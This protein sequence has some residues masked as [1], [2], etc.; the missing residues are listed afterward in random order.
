M[1]DHLP[2]FESEDIRVTISHWI[3]RVPGPRNISKTQQYKIEPLEIRTLLSGTSNEINF[4]QFE[5]DAP[6]SRR[7]WTGLQFP[8]DLLHPEQSGRALL[9]AIDPDGEYELVEVKHGLASSHSRFRQIVNG[10]PVFGT[11]VSAHQGSDGLIHTLHMQTYEQPAENTSPQI[12]EEQSIAISARANGVSQI[13]LEPTGQLVWFAT[14]N[15]ELQLAWETSVSSR[16][17]VV[18][19]FRTVI[20]AQTG[21]VLSKENRIVFATGSGDSFVPNP[22]QTQGNGT[23]LDDNNDANS[24]ALEAQLVSVTLERLDDG[25]GLLIGEWADLATFNS[26]TKPDND[27][28]EANRIYEYTRDD[29]RFE[30]VV[31]YHAIDSIQ[32]YFHSLGFDDDTGTANGIR[33]FPTL[34]NAHW[35]DDDQSF[36]STANDALHF[37]DGGVD[38]GEDQDI[39]A[40][41]YGHAVQHNQNANWSGGEMGAM[42]EGFG[43]YLAASFYADVGDANYQA[44]NAACVGEWDATEFSSTSPPCLRRVDGDKIYPDDLT[45]AIHAD[46]EIWSA[47]LWDIRAELGGPVTDQLVL[48]HHFALPAN[49]LMPDAANAVLQADVDLNNGDNQAE[50]LAAFVA[51]GILE[52]GPAGTISFESS[53][54]RIGDVATITVTDTDLIGQPSV[55]I[56]VVATSGDSETV[57]LMP[58]GPGEFSGTIVTQAGPANADSGILDVSHDDVLTATYQ[59]EDDGSGNANVVSD[60][61]TAL[62]MT[63]VL[64]ADFSDDAGAAFNEGFTLSGNAN[65]WHLST[66]RGTDP[67][68]SADDSFYFGSGESASGGGSY[69][70]DANGTVTSPSI[71]LGQA[72]AAHLSFNYFLEIESGFDV[73]SVSILHNSTT[74]EIANSEAGTLPATGSFNNLQFDLQQFLGETIRI[75]FQFTSDASVTFEGWYIDDVIVDASFGAPE[76]SPVLVNADP[77]GDKALEPGDMFDLDIEIQNTGQLLASGYHVGYYLSADDQ[78][79]GDDTLFG[80]LPGPDIPAGDVYVDTLTWTVPLDAAV[81]PW[82]VLV[83]V[84][85]LLVVT[86][87]DES[88]NVASDEIEVVAS[89]PDDQ[90]SEALAATVGASVQAEIDVPKDVDMF[91]FAAEADRRVGF[92]I[93]RLS[94][95]L[96]SHVRIFDATGVE[97]IANNDAVGPVPENDSSESYAEF[98][99]RTA[100]T[101]YVAVSAQGN[102]AYNAITGVG[103]AD[104]IGSGNYEL[105]LIDLGLDP[106]D[107]DDE[108]A[109]ANAIMPGDIVG[110]FG[111]DFAKDVDVFGFNV[112]AGDRIGFDIDRTGGDLNSV[113]RLFD[114][115]GNQLAI[116]NDGVGLDLESDPSDSYIDHTFADAGQYFVGVS[117][118]GNEEYNVLTGFND[119]ESATQGTYDLTLF[120]LLPDLSAQ[121]LALVDGGSQV[122]SGSTF[123]VMFGWQNNGRVT[124]SGYQVAFTLSQDEEPSADDIFLHSI[125]GSDLA[126]DSLFESSVELQMP[127]DIPAGTWYLHMHVDDQND[128][129]EF[130]ETDNV[131]QKTIDVPAGFLLTETEV[132]VSETGTQ[133]TF[134]AVLT[135]APRSDVI[136]NIQNANP[137][138]A[139]IDLT[140]LTFTPDDW[141][142]AQTVT[143]TGLNDQFADGD[144]EFDLTVSVD[145]SSDSAFTTLTSQTIAVT[146]SDDE[147]SE[148]TIVE[149]DG[150]TSTTESGAADLIEVTLSAAPVSD[151]ILNVNLADENQFATDVTALTFDGANWDTPQTVAVTAVDDLFVDGDAVSAVTFSVDQSSPANFAVLPDQTFSITG[152]DNDV[153]GVSV[154][155]T[156]GSTRTEES[157]LTDS[158]DI[159]LTAGPLTD[160]VFVIDI[161]ADTQAAVDLPQVTFTPENWDTPQSITASAVDDPLADGDLFIISNISVDTTVS[162]PAFI[163]LQDQSVLIETIDNEMAGFTFD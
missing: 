101:Y 63:P 149:T 138:E 156:D 47:A 92:D 136:L 119:T 159:V 49:S 28:N 15:N 32:A 58:S 150:T 65:A 140:T 115:T 162:D 53:T 110:G 129:R 95:D 68:H 25:T 91:A 70:N 78:L 22:W 7:T 79:S 88:N 42:G 84:D 128:L 1:S 131:I 59:D 137:A 130:S 135:T 23:G 146:N 8:G 161:P 6:G 50:I 81:Q 10:L 104:G 11:A 89:D 34:A 21:T 116:N 38:D 40:H 16:E 133:Q 143:I 30:Q 112:N 54:V 111:I 154:T 96:D 148:I 3:Q 113:L 73:A 55:D 108:V 77:D 114:S 139:S 86:E 102:V 100:D 19:D 39:V 144:R 46:G 120:E 37:G 27:A 52:A 72:E 20:D 99:F 31:I 82:N 83:V 117:G 121:S 127:A 61:A 75:A 24:A 4:A 123:D 145:E 85:E 98:T 97:L 80:S 152:A 62:L 66:G 93:D 158:F 126:A 90:I 2:V 57:T 122:D 153:A 67:G 107:P 151:L 160:V 74:T 125:V 163:S 109:E 44:A 155:E 103:D 56:A 14:A 105:L 147:I 35:N 157:G 87:L 17:G 26:P 106:I 124:A 9:S 142:T 45:G 132:A 94:G 71:D 5:V 18:G 118:D 51:R 76:L 12:S 48:E 29:D 69:G 134:D 41:E 141:S 60:T 64:E 36:Y 13:Y 43:D 33:D